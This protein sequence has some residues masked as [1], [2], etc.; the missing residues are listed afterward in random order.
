MVN[1][2]GL[3]IK[4]YDIYSKLLFL[5]TVSIDNINRFDIKDCY[6][7]YHSKKY[8]PEKNVLQNKTTNDCLRRILS[9][10]KSSRNLNLESQKHLGLKS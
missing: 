8:G 7:Q 3:Q 9:L 1:I 6:L 10:K 2:F 4:L 5:V